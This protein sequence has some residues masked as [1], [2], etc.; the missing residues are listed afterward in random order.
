MG[1]L[2]TI[3]QPVS[4][5]IGY[6][7]WNM[8]GQTPPVLYS[9]DLS[10]CAAIPQLTEAEI[11][12]IFALVLRSAGATIVHTHSHARA[13]AGMTC[14]LILSESHAA[15][16]T[17]PD[18]ATVNVDIFSCSARL[19]SLKAIDNLRGLLGARHACIQEVLRDDGHA[20]SVDQSKLISRRE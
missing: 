11:S 2:F 10:E 6:F 7:C 9:A 5:P 4:R 19:N 1:P 12:E 14:T 13:G 18:T 8:S 15:L 3:E 17:W 20:F 16:H